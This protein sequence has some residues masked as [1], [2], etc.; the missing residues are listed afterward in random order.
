MNNNSQLDSIFKYSCIA[1][2]CL[3][4]L[5]AGQVLFIPLFYGLFIAIVLF[6]FCRWLERHHFS[7]SAAIAAGLSI[8]IILFLGL[9]F[10][11]EVQINAFRQDL[12]ELKEKIAPSLANLQHWVADNFSVTIAT[13]NE[14]WQHA[15]NK[16][17]D[18]PEALLSGTVNKT[19]AAMFSLFLIPVFAAL[20][21]YN[22]ADFVLFAEKAV[23][24]TYHGKATQIM[25]Q[26]VDTYY[27]FIKGMAMVYVIVGI[28]NSVGLLALGIRHAIL[29]GFLTAIMTIIPYFGIFISALLPITVAWITKDSIWYPLGVVAIFTFVQ[30]LEANVIFPRVVAA[31][32]NVSTWATLVAIIGGGILWGV[33]GMILFIPLTGILKIITDNTEEWEAI[34][35]LLRRK[36][37][38]KG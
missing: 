25:Q 17:A 16:L 33:S 5:Y 19:I 9:L 8:V 24:K 7:R 35:T 12:P 13:Q 29:F 26:T 27:H 36:A 15:I 21:L 6:P 3:F 4:L 14:W 2:F 10:L 30:Y 28:L 34:N 38:P 23:G 22:R 37:K 32:L 11:V 20:F 18:D 1:A 31:E